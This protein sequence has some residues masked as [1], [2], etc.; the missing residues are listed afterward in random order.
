[1]FVVEE[2]FVDFILRE[3]RCIAELPDEVVVGGDVVE[4]FGKG[5]QSMECPKGEGEEI[6]G[7]R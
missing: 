1:M 3:K 5:R 6:Q 2:G 7:L 4:L